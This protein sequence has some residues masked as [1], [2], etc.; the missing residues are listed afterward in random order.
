MTRDWK[1]SLGPGA[2]EIQIDPVFAGQNEQPPCQNNT[3]H[4][5]GTP[6]KSPTFPE[7]NQFFNTNGNQQHSDNGQHGT[8]TNM[9]TN[10]PNRYNKDRQYWRYHKYDHDRRYG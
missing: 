8:F 2:H 7:Q 6:L 1:L 4:G 3:P 5:D 10:N 9:G